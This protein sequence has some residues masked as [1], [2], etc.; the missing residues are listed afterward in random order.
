MRTYCKA[1]MKFVDVTAL[2]DASV[3]SGDNQIFGNPE[4]FK[5]ETAQADYGTLERNQF[6]LDGSRK[7]MPDVPEDVA[8]WSSTMSKADCTFES[9]P[10][11]TILFTSTHTSAGLTLYFAGE[12]PA[13][14]RI[15]W[16]DT[17]LVKI[18]SEVYYPDA[19]CY[20]CNKQ[21]QNYGKI[22]IEF[23]RTMLPERY[24]KLQYILYGKYILWDADTVKSAKLQ[25]DIDTTSITLPINEADISIVDVNNDFDAENEG[26]AWKSVQKTQEVTLT[27]Y[28]N[29][30]KIPLGAFFIDGFSFSKNVAKFSLVDGIGLLDRYTFYDGEIYANTKAE[31]ILQAIFAAAGVTKYAV[32]EEVGNIL[33][34][35][36]LGVQSCRDA[37]QKVCFACGAVADDSRSNTIK[38]Y[39][40]DRYV[41]ATVGTDRKFNGGTVVSL[42]DYV[43]GVSV[44]CNRYTL[45]EE[46][47]DIYDENLPA[48]DTRLTF[49]EPYLPASI[50]ATAG[51]LKEIKTNYLVIHMD[52]SG[53]TK[54]SGKRYTGTTFS[55]QKNVDVI[56]AGETEN[57][58]KIS[59]STLYNADLLP[60]ITEDLLKYYA[61][62]KSV[63]MKY[64]LEEEHV[65]N[66]VNIKSITGKT[67]TTLIESQSIDLAK[68]YIATADCRG[69]SVVVTDFYYT[70]S[71]LYAGG[72][73]II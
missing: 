34:S 41:T 64:L 21:V 18:I 44:E 51:T 16:Y 3:S 19:L 30:D 27:E 11:L 72:D 15:T 39:K 63:R 62:R 7:I 65:G 60:E 47:S 28:Y 14:L 12:Y 46:E 59:A 69:Y 50:T 43:S 36:Y 66:W 35:G 42:E 20:V 13:E 25:E 73:V 38:V 54:I 71:E 26:G 61:L 10:K 29:G 9:N 53:Q 22:E 70:G 31:I 45:D 1:E 57:I 67:S 32:E 33:L 24:V 56:D 8:F 2:S 49:S 5:S 23:I 37:L 40:P 58:K 68:G 55:Y 4:I 48:G 52:S 6:V 17:N